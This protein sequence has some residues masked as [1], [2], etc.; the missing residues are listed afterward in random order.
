MAHGRLFGN[1]TIT[2]NALKLT[3]TSGGYVGLPGGLV[4]WSAA[5]TFEF[6]ATFGTNAD[7]AR[8]FDFGATNGNNGSQYV[9]FSPRTAIGSHRLEIVTAQ[10]S[11]TRDPT[12]TLDSRTVHV[13]CILD[14]TNNYA[15]IYT[16]GVLELAAT[17]TIPALTGV[18]T[19]LGYLGRSLFNFDG[20]LNGTI[21]EFRIY[22]G[23]LTPQE[24]AANFKAGPDALALPMTLEATPVANILDLQ[25]P[26]YGAGFAVEAVDQLAAPPWISLGTT[27]V[28]S[29]GYYRVTQPATNGV[30]FFRLKR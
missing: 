11:F 12:P 30:N 19:N 15:A 22:D 24:I 3:G 26:S 28:I 20:W 14:R 29:N 21:D 17:A 18:S 10:G 9:F 23:R 2:N 8:V 27:P 16:N 4:S 1:A 7:W 25:W 5:A 6:W 13:V